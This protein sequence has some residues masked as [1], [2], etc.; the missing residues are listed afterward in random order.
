MASSQNC[1]RSLIF[2]CWR[3]RHAIMAGGRPD[4]TE[5]WWPSDELVGMIANHAKSVFEDK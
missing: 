4:G 3:F 5:W 2:A 1:I